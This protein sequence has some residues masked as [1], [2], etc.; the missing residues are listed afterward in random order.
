[1]NDLL[2][3]A[4][5]SSQ[6]GDRVKTSTHKQNVSEKIIGETILGLK[7]AEKGTL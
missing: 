2:Y 7:I 6:K 5:F 1:M 4:Q 3:R